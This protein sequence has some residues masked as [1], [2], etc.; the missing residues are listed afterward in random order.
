MRDEGIHRGEGRARGRRARAAQ[1]WSHIR[2][3]AGSGHGILG[4]AAAWRE[5]GAR[6]CACPQTLGDAGTRTRFGR[7]TG[8]APSRRRRSAYPDRADTWTRAEGRRIARPYPT[9]QE[10]P[11]RPDDLHSSQRH[12]PGLHHPRCPGRRSPHRSRRGLSS[13]F[14]SLHGSRAM[15]FNLTASLLVI[16]ALLTLSAFLAGSETA[17][18]AV[19]KARMHRLAADGSWRARQTIRLIADRERLI[20][21][22]LLGNTFINILASALATSVAVQ[23]FGGSGVVI[24]TFAMTT[25][26]LIFTEVVPKTLAI[27]HTDRFALTVSA[28]VGLFVSILA[29]IVSAVRWMV[30]RVLNLFGVRPDEDA[31]VL[32][33]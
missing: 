12:W 4:S 24:A 13:P 31:P 19:S 9:R 18:T 16:F 17:L 20:G 25:I 22:L 15:T 11:W 27:T 6:M 26:I 8:R 32:S 10:G 2:S 33:A 5:R 30:W 1:P 23:H 7:D 14:V 29:P 3:C 28:L 21:A